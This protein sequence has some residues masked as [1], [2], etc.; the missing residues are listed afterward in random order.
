M[1]DPCCSGWQ[2]GILGSVFVKYQPDPTLVCE[3]LWQTKLPLV[4]AT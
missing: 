4:E 3:E 2:V 1:N